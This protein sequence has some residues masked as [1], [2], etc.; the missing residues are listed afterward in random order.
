MEY[1]LTKPSEPQEIL[2]VVNRC[3][4]KLPAA[5]AVVAADFDREH[6]RLLTDK[7]SAVN[8]R[9]EQMQRAA[10]RPRPYRFVVRRVAEKE[11]GQKSR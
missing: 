10:A 11:K 5:A 4:G 8:R 3:L 9:L 6:M 2:Q 1:V 7:L